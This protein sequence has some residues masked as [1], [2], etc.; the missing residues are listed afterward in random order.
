MH[1]GPLT[2]LRASDADRTLWTGELRLF[3]RVAFD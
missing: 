2:L 1:G 3:G